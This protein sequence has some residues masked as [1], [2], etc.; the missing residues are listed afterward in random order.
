[1][2]LKTA[3]GLQEE[4]WSMPRKGKDE[5]RFAQS[6]DTERMAGLH[7]KWNPSSLI[8]ALL[9]A[10]R[11]HMGIRFELCVQTAVYRRLVGDSLCDI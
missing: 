2:F 4:T 11:Y 7:S 3:K 1:M 5:L 9:L 6:K 8:A 10:V